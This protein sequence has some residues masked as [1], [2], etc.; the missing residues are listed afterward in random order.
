VSKRRRAVWN[1]EKHARSLLI[2]ARY[3]ARD[4]ARH[5]ANGSSKMTDS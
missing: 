5:D 1:A 3:P 2:H 4:A